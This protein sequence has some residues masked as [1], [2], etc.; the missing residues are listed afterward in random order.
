MPTGNILSTHPQTN[1]LFRQLDG[2]IL[3]KMA[4]KFGLDGQCPKHPIEQRTKLHYDKAQSQ[5]E[6]ILSER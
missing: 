4:S 3:V 2:E 5:S 1:K 6:D